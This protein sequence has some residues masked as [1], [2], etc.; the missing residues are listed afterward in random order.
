MVSPANFSCKTW[1][2]RD[3]SQP[4]VEARHCQNRS[5]SV[6]PGALPQLIC[7]NRISTP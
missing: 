2:G 1:D 4:G 5:Y 6:N 7:V 3:A